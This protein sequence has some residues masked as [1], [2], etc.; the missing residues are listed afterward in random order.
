MSAAPMTKPATQGANV[1]M[2]TIVF[3][4][5]VLTL[6]ACGGGGG[7]SGTTSNPPPTVAP[8]SVPQGQLVTPK[9]TI[10]VPGKSTSSTRRGP[11]FV[12]SASLSIT[13]TLTSVGGSAP[14]VTP[15]SVT[16]SISG[17]SCTSVNPCVVNGPP[18][19]PGQADAYTLATFDAA[20]GAGNEL[21]SGAVT[22]TPTAGIN[23]VENVTLVGIPFSVTITGVP[24]GFAANTASQTANLAVTVADHAGQAITGT[25]ANPVRITDPDADTTNGTR[26]TGTHPGSGC[27]NSC[28]DLLTNTDTI[29]LN[30][31]GLAENAVVLASSATGVTGGNAGT[32]TFTPLLNAITGD[33]TNP[34][35]TLAGGGTGIDLYTNDST[36]PVGYTGTVK[37]AELG[38]TNSPYNKALS[39]TGGGACS[40]FATIATLANAANETPFTATSIAGPSGGQCTITVTDGL[41]DQP[42]PLP[43]FRVSYTTSQIGA[44]SKTR[45]P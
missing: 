27:T 3:L 6:A 11:T 40:T 31:G 19:P 39:V 26:L 23:N 35:T 22:F 33:G 24:A 8:T 20:G 41:T 32:A 2:R 34:S 4:A 42:H 16:S 5:A 17:A 28:V 9:F 44:S 43:T 37:Y 45:K 14:V 15:T 38:F 36:S 29:A 10:V 12:S 13:I 30:Y 18:S 21:D 1:Q 7:G 25:Y